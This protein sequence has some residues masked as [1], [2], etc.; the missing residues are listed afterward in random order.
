M[1][2]IILKN[3]N[4][5][6]C[7]GGV[8]YGRVL[9]VE[10]A[11]DSFTPIE[12]GAWKWVRK[13]DKPVDHIRMELVLFGDPT[14]TMVPAVSYNGNGW[15]TFPEYVGDRDKDGTPWSWASHRVTVPSCT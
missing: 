3:G 10:G 12:N 7:A 13:T 9:P 8:A 4:Y 15:G 1:T 6:L 5:A 11:S 14:F 2:E